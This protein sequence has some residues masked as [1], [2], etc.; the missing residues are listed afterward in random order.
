M[1]TEQLHPNQLIKILTG[2]FSGDLQIL[3]NK[4]NHGIG[5]TKNIIDEVLA[6]DFGLFVSQAVFAQYH[7]NSAVLVNDV[8][9]WGR[10][11]N[12]AL[13]NGITLLVSLVKASCSNRAN[14]SP[15][16]CHARFFSL[17]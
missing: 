1:F 5:M 8:L 11:V 7:P 10:R 14:L 9:S 15:S 12:Y 17:A 13:R 4:F 3:T 6:I 2:Y 16:I